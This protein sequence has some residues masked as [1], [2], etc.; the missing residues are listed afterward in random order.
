M[1]TVEDREEEIEVVFV[2]AEVVHLA[3]E[4]EVGPLLLWLS[5]LGCMTIMSLCLQSVRRLRCV[6]G[7][8]AKAFFPGG[9][10]DR[11]GRGGGGRGAPR[12][13]GVPRGGGRGGARGGSKFGAKGGA[14][15][16]IVRLQAFASKTRAQGLYRNHIGI[17]ESSSLVAKKICWSR[18]ILHQESQSTERR[19]SRSNLVVLRT[20]K[21]RQPPRRN[22]VSGTLS[23]PRYECC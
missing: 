21:L 13:R 5:L 7:A 15:T 11:G 3:V 20:A 6:R 18:R 10:G 22:T 9:F 17:R 8:I 14:K 1:E 12:G 19:E 2:E 4:V 16:I 23:A